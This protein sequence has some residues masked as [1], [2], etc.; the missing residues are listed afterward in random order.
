MSISNPLLQFCNC[1]QSGSSKHAAFLTSI[2]YLRLH[3]AFLTWKKS[4]HHL[5]QHT[6]QLFQ[7]TSKQHFKPISLNRP[8]QYFSLAGMNCLSVI[9]PLSS[10]EKFRHASANRKRGFRGSYEN[11]W[12]SFSAY[13]Q[14]YNCLLYKCAFKLINAALCCLS[15]INVHL[16]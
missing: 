11:S 15:F 3:P 5:Y 1:A 10:G 9:N 2:F 16:N 13:Y 8:N 6:R 7:P 12:T 14:F 4:K